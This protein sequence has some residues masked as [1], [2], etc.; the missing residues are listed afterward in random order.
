MRLAGGVLDDRGAEGERGGHDRVL[1][2][3]DRGLVEEH[4]GA[5]QLLRGGEDVLA[6]A[7]LDGAAERLQGEDMGVDAAAADHVAARERQPHVAAA[8]EQRPGEQDR[9]ADLLADL[10][11]RLVA[12]D[13]VGPEGDRARSAGRH[14]DAEVAEDRDQRLHV[15]D[16]GH[17]RQDHFVVG[18]ERRRDQRQGGVLVAARTNP[19][20]DRVTAFDHEAL[21]DHHVLHRSE[22]IPASSVQK[23][24]RVDWAPRRQT[25]RAGR[26][27]EESEWHRRSTSS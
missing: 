19:A 6:A 26:P 8:R 1:G 21:I 22:R 7:G 25:T 24:V 27:E 5:D 9:G 3:R 13:A 17:I 14:G 10:R 23:E 12:V 20:A 16:G 4:V 11:V 2:A 15:S 18:Q